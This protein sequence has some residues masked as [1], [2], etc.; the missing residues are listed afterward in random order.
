MNRIFGLA[1][2]AVALSFVLASCEPAGETGDMDDMPEAT[3]EA[4]EPIE[5]EDALT[6]NEIGVEDIVSEP[7]SFA[8]RTVTVTGDLEEVVGPRAFKL[9]EDAPLQGGIDNDLLVLGK[10][11]AGLDEIDDQWLDNRVRV[12]GTVRTMTVVEIEREVGWDLDPEIEA[13][14]EGREAVL[15]ADAV[16]RVPD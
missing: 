5:R 7:A 4:S 11:T 3:P 8:G 1:G 9:D 13:E 6:A 16:Q 12:T 14:L 10:Q 15:I 2:S